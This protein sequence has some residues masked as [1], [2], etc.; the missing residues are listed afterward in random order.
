MDKKIRVR[1]YK[2]LDDSYSLVLER[3]GQDACDGLTNLRLEDIRQLAQDITTEWAKLHRE[4]QGYEQGE[5]SKR[6]KRGK[7]YSVI[8]SDLK[9]RKYRTVEAYDEEDA[10][11][12]FLI[13]HPHEEI[14]EINY[15]KLK[16][17]SCW[18]GA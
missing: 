13:L 9:Y 3:T 4:T 18:G 7:W 1:I 10:R 16:T 14:I 12:K 5:V 11:Q 17:E 15:N 8:T 6:G 2:Y